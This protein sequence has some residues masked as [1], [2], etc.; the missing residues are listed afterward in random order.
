MVALAVAAV[1][2]LWL[3]AVAEEAVAVVLEVEVVVEAVAAVMCLWLVVEVAV[4]VEEVV[5]VVLEVEVA[6]VAEEDLPVAADS[7]QRFSDFD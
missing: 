1:L 6:V 3:F 2:C 7:R 5:A 4:V